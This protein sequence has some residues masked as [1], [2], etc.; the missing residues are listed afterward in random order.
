[1]LIFFFIIT[2]TN[3]FIINPELNQINNTISHWKHINELTITQT[4]YFNN[5]LESFNVHIDSIGDFGLTF[6]LNNKTIKV[7]DS[8]HFIFIHDKIEYIIT[9]IT[10]YKHIKNITIT[11][12]SIGL[13][14]ADP[15]IITLDNFTYELNTIGEFYLAYDTYLTTQ[16]RHTTAGTN[17]GTINSAVAIQY[18]TYKITIECNNN[19][20]Y[21]FLNSPNTITYTNTSKLILVDT[22]A[23][24]IGLLFIS[25]DKE[26][27][28]YNLYFNA[29]GH[30]V[31]VIIRKNQYN[32]QFMSVILSF[33]D[34]SKN[35]ISGLL[36]NYDGNDS[37][38]LM[39]PNGTVLNYKNYTTNDLYSFA[40]S[41]RLNSSTSIFYYLSNKDTDSYQNMLYPTFNTSAVL[42][43]PVTD[44]TIAK[45][46]C[47]NAIFIN[48]C[49]YDVLVNQDLEFAVSE[50]ELNYYVYN[51]IIRNF[52]FSIMF[53]N[54][55]TNIIMYDA[56]IGLSIVAGIMLIIIIVLIIII[57]SCIYDK[58]APNDEIEL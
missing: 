44:Y 1:M 52:N 48:K 16:I 11:H 21:L 3:A 35:N 56:I 13:T 12:P 49:I 25:Q 38:D 10:N 33:P 19:L 36:G 20:P 22:N 31:Y 9:T 27:L 47:V 30:Q 24:Y 34:T 58:K 51:D 50:Y 14:F 54:T 55:N 6:Q 28:T 42:F 39:F 45:N 8:H 26:C 2:C 18:N 32:S 15:Y 43:F 4:V 37:N 23:N 57:I 29:T 17:V 40:N 53:T 7:T 46:A 5:L 41:Y